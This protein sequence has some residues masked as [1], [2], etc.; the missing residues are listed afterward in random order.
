MSMK[1]QAVK[2]KKTFLK[3]RKDF[4][5]TI[6]HHMKSNC[7]ESSSIKLWAAEGWL[8]NAFIICTTL[9][10]TCNHIHLSSAGQKNFFLAQSIHA[11]G[12]TSKYILFKANKG[13]S[14]MQLKLKYHHLRNS[15]AFWLQGN[16]SELLALKKIHLRFTGPPYNIKDSQKLLE[17]IK[18]HK[19]QIT[20]NWTFEDFIREKFYTTINKNK[21]KQIAL[22]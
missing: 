12:K 4:Q 1:L 7:N 3:L 5:R 6:G 11:S 17:H 8:A 13:G 21:Q 16:S 10:S 22:G 15:N 18:M 14:K 19:A 9:P 20:L 2:G